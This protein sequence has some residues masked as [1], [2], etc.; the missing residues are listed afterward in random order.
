MLERSLDE[1]GEQRVPVPRRGGELRMELAGQKP[2]MVRSSIIST[3]S[4]SAERPDTTS[5]A[6]TS[7]GR[8]RL[9]TS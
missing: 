8:K 1:A 9:L 4:P 7:R 6:S 3:S 2:G 5:P